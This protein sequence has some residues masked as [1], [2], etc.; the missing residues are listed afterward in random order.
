MNVQ[1]P[2]ACWPTVRTTI[3]VTISPEAIAAAYTA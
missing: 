3:G 2:K 1:T